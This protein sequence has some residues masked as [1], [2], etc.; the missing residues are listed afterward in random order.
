MDHVS[1]TN[2]PQ[3]LGPS[4]ALGSDSAAVQ[5]AVLCR[6]AFYARPALGGVCR[7]RHAGKMDRGLLSSCI[8]G[9]AFCDGLD[10]GYLGRWGRSVAPEDLARPAAGRHPFRCLAREFW[11]KS[12]S[13]G[14]PRICD[15]PG[16]YG[17]R[18]RRW[19]RGSK[20]RRKRTLITDLQ[21]SRAWCG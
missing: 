4:S 21:L 10:G 6:V 5:A 8:F 2:P 7:P 12:Y 18:Y 11:F 15:S 20:T 17:A 9:P 1:R 13:V 14:Q 3:L 19:K 16:S